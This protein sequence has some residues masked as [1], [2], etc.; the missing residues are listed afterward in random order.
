[1]VR[2]LA[3][4]FLTVYGFAQPRSAP[5]PMKPLHPLEE[6]YLRWNVLPAFWPVWSRAGCCIG[7]GT[8]RHP[9]APKSSAR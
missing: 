4:F 5:E 6:S 2:T 1:M 3:C 9:P 7:A 8:C